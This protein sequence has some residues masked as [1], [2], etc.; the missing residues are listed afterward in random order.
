MFTCRTCARLKSSK[1]Q[2]TISGNGCSI[3]AP[4]IVDALSEWHCRYFWWSNSKP[5][6]GFGCKHWK[7]FNGKHWL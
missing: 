6:K 1:C 5:Q 4:S 7:N 3:S 2:L